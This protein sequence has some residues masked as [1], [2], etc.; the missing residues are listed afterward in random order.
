[1]TSRSSSATIAR[2]Y[3]TPPRLRDLVALYD[4]DA[5]DGEVRFRPS[6]WESM[7]GS[8]PAAMLALRALRDDPA[9]HDSVHVVGDRVVIRAHLEAELDALDVDEES[10]DEALLRAFLL[11]QAWGIGLSGGGRAIANTRRAFEHRDHLVASLRR[12]AQTLRSSGDEVLLVTAHNQWAAEGV[13]QSFFTKWFAFAGR[14]AGR[15]WQP[16][17]L[18]RRVYATLNQTIEVDT[19]ELAGIDDWAQ[20]YRTYVIAMHQ[21]ADQLK[22][23]A[24]RLEWVLFEHAGADL[25]A[26]A[27]R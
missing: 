12:T 11:V 3:P 8:A 16:L 21:W 25:S 18:D 1:M 15:A 19:Q 23:S 6:T 27:T 24:A 7:L 10:A 20:A 17:I 4:G 22:M 9:T 13:R 26:R 5:S 14:R 2:M